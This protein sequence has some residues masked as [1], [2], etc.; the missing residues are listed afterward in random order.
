MSKKRSGQKLD[1]ERLNDQIWRE[2]TSQ[3]RGW[4]GEIVMDR[5]WTY[6]ECWPETGH[7]YTAGQK[8]DT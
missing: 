3:D 2:K 6:E 5:H 7:M 4:T 8:M 1:R